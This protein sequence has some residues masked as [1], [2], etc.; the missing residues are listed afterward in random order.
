M[1]NRARLGFGREFFFFFARSLSR[2]L[3]FSPCHQLL[4]H[5]LREH[6]T[7]GF[8]RTAAGGDRGCDEPGEA[9]P[10]SWLPAEPPLLR[11]GPEHVGAA[12][13]RC[14]H[15]SRAVPSMCLCRGTRGRTHPPTP[16]TLRCLAW[17][18]AWRFPRAAR[19]RRCRALPSGKCRE[20]FSTRH[21]D[22]SRVATAQG[23][24]GETPGPGGGPWGLG[25][26]A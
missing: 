1:S 23:R 10:P 5:S 19:T 2:S 15:V 4:T 25:S 26:S 11:S 20:A 16:H 7:D 13:G 18:P 12:R 24:E 8:L 3:L 21:F 17:R 14:Y 22:L 9:P 6:G